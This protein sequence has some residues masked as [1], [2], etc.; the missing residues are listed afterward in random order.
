MGLIALAAR[1]VALLASAAAALIAVTTALVRRG[2]LQPFGAWARLVRRLSDPILR[3]IERGLARA[4]GNPQDA[5]AWLL[6]FAVVGG[7]VLIA[8]ADWLVA[9]ALRQGVAPGA[10]PRQVAAFLVDGTYTV[11][12]V[13]LVARAIGSWVGIGGSHPM[14]RPLAWLTDWLVAPIRRRLPP[15]GMLDL[16]PLVAFLLLF[17]VRALLLGALR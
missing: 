16:S 1:A 14:M 15:A 3:P 8:V 11:L 4:G 7:L 5:P 9:L 17:L 10:G 6:G 2:R 13:A 12:V